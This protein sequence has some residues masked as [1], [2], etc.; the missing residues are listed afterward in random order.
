MCAT[1]LQLWRSNFGR[2]HQSAGAVVLAVDVSHSCKQLPTQFSAVWILLPQDRQGDGRYRLLYVYAICKDSL[3]MV[4]TDQGTGS[5][6][7]APGGG[8]GHSMCRSVLP[9]CAM[10]T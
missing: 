1:G 9:V 7:D 2:C 4:V 5:V 6:G 8:M 3:F 10:R